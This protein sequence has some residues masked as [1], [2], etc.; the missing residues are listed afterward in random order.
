MNDEKR[1]TIS[2]W[3]IGICVLILTIMF[4]YIIRTHLCNN[5]EAIILFVLSIIITEAIYT[6]SLIN[7]KYE[8]LPWWFIQFGAMVFSL[9]ILLGCMLVAGVILLTKSVTPILV[10]A[11]IVL[12]F[13]ANKKYS[14]YLN[15][16]N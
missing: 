2:K 11:I 14:E 16:V 15:K 7:N 5:A 9:M 13:W 8:Q 1:K 4:S 12:F 6:I 10:I 3:I